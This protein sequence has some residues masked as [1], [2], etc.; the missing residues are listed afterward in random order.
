MCD[1]LIAMPTNT[2]LMDYFLDNVLS[3]KHPILH[4]PLGLRTFNSFERK[5]TPRYKYKATRIMV[6]DPDFY[7]Y[8]YYAFN[9]MLSKYKRSYTD[10]NNEEERIESFEACK[11]WLHRYIKSRKHFSE[12]VL[13]DIVGQYLIVY[14]ETVAGEQD[15]EIVKFII[16]YWDSCFLKEYH[17]HSFMRYLTSYRFSGEDE[18]LKLRI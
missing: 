17:T 10:L 15:T 8:N 6:K 5:A 1:Q 9:L 11:L 14:V 16:D 12:E 7:F 13:Y 2:Q 3:K 4:T 18:E